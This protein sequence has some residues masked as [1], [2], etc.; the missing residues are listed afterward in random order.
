MKPQNKLKVVASEKPQP[1]D[2][3]ETK[4]IQRMM[5]LRSQLLLAAVRFVQ[6]GKTSSP[7]DRL[8]MASDMTGIPR[9]AI[10]NGLGRIK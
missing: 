2:Y 5:F 3:N 4:G 10:E 1:K 8:R 7:Q 9:V 6:E